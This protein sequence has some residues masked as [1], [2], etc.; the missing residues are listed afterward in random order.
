VLDASG[1]LAVHEAGTMI[2][3][4]SIEAGG[5]ILSIGVIQAQA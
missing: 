4:G 5:W 2:G 3:A 1:R